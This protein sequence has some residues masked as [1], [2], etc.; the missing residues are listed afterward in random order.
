MFHPL[1]ALLVLVPFLAVHGCSCEPPTVV[2][3]GLTGLDVTFEI[4]SALEA[5]QV[6]LSAC[7]AGGEG[8]ELV[9][10][11]V[12]PSGAGEPLGEEE[13]LVVILPDELAGTELLLESWALV[14]G[15]PV[16]FAE[17]IVTVLAGELVPVRLAL[18]FE[19]CDEESCPE[20]KVCVD[21]QCRPG[22]LIDGAFH[23][24][25][26]TAFDSPCLVCDP[27]ESS[28]SWTADCEADEVCT[29]LGCEQGCSIE[30]VFREPNELAPDDPC[31][32]CDPAL[33]V[34]GWSA[35]PVGH[36]CDDGD[37]CTVDTFCDDTGACGQGDDRCTGDECTIATC[38]A[39]ETRCEHD[40]QPLGT[41]CAGDWF[42]DGAGEC[43]VGCFIEG[44][45]FEPYATR[46]GWECFDCSPLLSNTDWTDVCGPGQVCTEDGCA[47][48]CRIDDVYFTPGHRNPSDP[49]EACEPSVAV[50]E[51]SRLPEL[52]PCDDGDWCTVNNVCDA[53]GVCGGDSPMCPDTDCEVATCHREEQECEYTPRPAGTS[54]GDGWFCDGDGACR[55]GCFIGGAFH[56]PMAPGP[57]DQ[58]VCDPEYSTEQW[59]HVLVFESVQTAEWF[60]PPNV[61]E[62][63]VKA[64]GAGGG[65]GGGGNN[66]RGGRGGG[67]G[68]A[69]A[70]L[71]VSPDESLTVHVGGGGSA[72]YGG[73][74]GAG[75]G[76]GGYSG[77][78]DDHGPLVIA[79][80]GG[81]GGG[82]DNQ[83]GAPDG[84]YGGGG[85]GFS[86]LAGDGA[87]GSVEGGGGGTQDEAGNAGNGDGSPQPGSS[88]AGGDGGHLDGNRVSGGSH[89]GGRGG[90][91]S[92][93]G[94]R[95]GGGG[96]GGGYHG[97]GGGGGSNAG[98]T[99]GGGGG[100]GSSFV[101][102][103]QT[104]TIEGAVVDAANE[105]DRHHVGEAGRGGARGGTESAGTP[106]ND[107]LTILIFVGS[108]G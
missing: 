66:R 4:D 32:H 33:D 68:F 56:D 24:P 59:T 86:G 83:S 88:L 34:A 27:A 10:P 11:V 23:E 52:T 73:G 31:L 108:C 82:G 54:C 18:H 93:D 65:G 45:L 36:P 13:T 48:G 91:P 77:L 42:C 94:Y 107:G 103:S 9:E 63:T 106:G 75:G 58:C 43:K 95:P 72:G 21:G 57:E 3:Q 20:G 101:S 30:D 37:W 60:V 64:W 1:L 104:D 99:S 22:C 55:L 90:G 87:G 50:D 49:C 74:S 8:D 71:E 97:G 17:S 41:P 15:A 7:I 25:G 78:L 29:P 14:E 69:T 81:G 92:S 85:G 53:A 100:G 96:G 61:T 5:T 70:K 62:V 2:Q 28:S 6:S 38:I 84:G 40:H 79:A 76:G 16:A 39:D 80:G 26:D 35:L 89:G 44:E 12:L 51:W 46:P 105:G 67:G 98:N 102:G 47:D 19:P